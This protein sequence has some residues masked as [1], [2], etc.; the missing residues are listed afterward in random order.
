M[1]HNLNDTSG[2][3]K[4]TKSP[5]NTIHPLYCVSY[6]AGRFRKLTILLQLIMLYIMF[7]LVVCV[8][9]SFLHTVNEMKAFRKIISVCLSVCI[10]PPSTSRFGPLNLFRFSKRQVDSSRVGLGVQRIFYSRCMYQS[11]LTMSTLRALSRLSLIV[12][13][14]LLY[15]RT[16]NVLI[17]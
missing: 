10:P 1:I 3:A 16:Y 15:F 17:W 6:S 4:C 11:Y 12:E 5:R 8:I 2:V 7:T 14:P 13:L 9:V